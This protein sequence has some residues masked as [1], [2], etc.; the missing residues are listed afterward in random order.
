MLS[1]KIDE[2][3]LAIGC[4]ASHFT[5]RMKVLNIGVTDW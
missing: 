2:R 5:V 4:L 1:A 3:R